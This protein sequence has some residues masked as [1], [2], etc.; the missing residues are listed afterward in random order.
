MGKN[1][2]SK[3]ETEQLFGKASN[4]QEFIIKH[5][6]Q[7]KSL[8]GREMEA[9]TLMAQGLEHT[10]IAEKLKVKSKTLQNY[11]N[12]IQKKLGIQNETGYIKFALAFGLISF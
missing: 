8:T 6:K 7:F 3:K 4:L 9:L 12:S 5:E 11:R 1:G 10:V 2:T